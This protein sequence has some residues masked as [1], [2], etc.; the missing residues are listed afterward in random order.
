MKI[1]FMLKGKI[2]EIWL[3]QSAFIRNMTISIDEIIKENCDI[4]LYSLNND[5]MKLNKCKNIL[6][7]L[8]E[9]K[10]VQRFCLDTNTN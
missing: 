10:I 2:N 3:K 8:N 4:D 1:N 9:E 5:I 7:K 6:D